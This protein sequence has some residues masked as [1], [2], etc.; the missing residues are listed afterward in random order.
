M[1]PIELNRSDV[2]PLYAQI[3]MEISDRISR[4]DLPSGYRLP[5]TRKLA[6]QTGVHRNTIIAAYRQLISDG[7]ARSGVGSGTFVAQPAA[8]MGR[9]VS[10]TEGF[11]WQRLLSNTIPGD[12]D[13]VGASILRGVSVPDNAILLTG[14]VPDR[15]QFPMDGFTRCAREILSS[16]DPTML[17]YGSP[18]GYQPL[19]SW[20]ADW[21]HDSGVERIDLNRIFIVNG[22]QQGLDLLARLFLHS[23]DQVVLEEPT[24][25]G[26]FMVLGQTGARM[27]GVPV[28]DEGISVS[29]LEQVLDREPVKF[30]YTM[31]AYQNPTGLC[32]SD[33][34]REELLA[35]SRRRGL[36]IVEDHYD[37]PLFY[38][39]QQPRFL[40]ADDP[41]GQVIHLGTFSKI[42]F[43]GLRLGWMIMPAELCEPLRKLK[44]ATDLSSGMLTQRVMEAFCRGGHLTDHLERLRLLN[45]GRLAAMLEALETYF[46]PSATWTRPSGGMTL[47]VELPP[48]ID[49]LELYR[50]AAC[51]GVL[52]TPGTAFYPNGGGRNAIRLS[53]NRE[54]RK[55]I[56]NGVR[57]LGKLINE[58]LSNRGDE[59]HPPG[60]AV[61]FL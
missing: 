7:L 61:P 1:K 48:S 53:F 13:L 41:N 44:R 28:D 23:G 11:S 50:D 20:L 17:D 54:N 33:R 56:R 14:A 32:L 38:E 9:Q 37:T 10:E 21:L 8:A 3:A 36:A 29:R 6:E 30:L 45:R 5:A 43:P 27:I 19:R 52:F 22:S 58:N 12:P 34:R 40:L 31:P 60:D 42:L 49:A 35:L 51:Q 2:M 59:V 25:S 18:E 46:P 15:R 26:V 39:G 47:W 4:G 55:R 57:L 24:Y 16:A